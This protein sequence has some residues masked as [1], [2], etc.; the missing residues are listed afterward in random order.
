ME[1]HGTFAAWIV[2]FCSPAVLPRNAMP[3]AWLE[4]LIWR[5]WPKR[6]WPSRRPQSHAID[7][8]CGPKQWDFQVANKASKAIGATQGAAA[9]HWVT[10]SCLESVICNANE[11]LICQVAKRPCQ[12]N[13]ANK[14]S[15][16][17]QKLS[18]QRHS[19]PDDVSII[20]HLVLRTVSSHVRT[21]LA[22][23]WNL[24]KT[25]T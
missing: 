1:C 7:E 17:W 13:R 16:V 20:R 24:Q 3:F 8:I 14:T 23:L 6:R 18:I 22:L 2:F 11:G 10:V 4:G 25:L 21:G 15:L 19:G 5:A 12:A 9:T